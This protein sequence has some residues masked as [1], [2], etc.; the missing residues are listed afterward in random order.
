MD[1]DNEFPQPSYREREAIRDYLQ[2]EYEFMPPLEFYANPFNVQYRRHAV[3]TMVRL[4]QGE[5]VDAYIPYLAMNY[6]DRFVSMNPLAELRGFSL[7]DKVRLVAI[8]CFTL[9]AKMRTTHFLPRQFQ[10]N[11]EVNFNSEK[12]MQTEFCILNGLNWRMRSITP[13]HFLDHYY[14]TFRM[15][16]GFKRR[17]INEIIVQSQGGIVIRVV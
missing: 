3:S 5:D 2:I 13:F 12:I 8:C 17:S 11:R 10:M 9:S 4:S 7:H 16:G 1:S 15:I 14:P 6:F